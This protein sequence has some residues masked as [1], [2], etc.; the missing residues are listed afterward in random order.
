MVYREKRLVFDGR[1]V[2]VHHYY[3]PFGAKHIDY[4]SIRQA[5]VTKPARNRLW[6]S[7]D[8]VRW[9]NL[10]VGR[11]RKTTAIELDLGRRCKPVITPDDPE[12]VL[13]ELR[14]AGVPVG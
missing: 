10:D 13:A 14:G 4:G 2:T 8:F 6:G 7:S 9:Y 1:Q 11:P 5:R 3:F 12:Q